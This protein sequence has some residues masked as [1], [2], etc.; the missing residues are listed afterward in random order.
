MPGFAEVTP[1]VCGLLKHL[2]A[3]MCCHSLIINN[4]GNCKN[5]STHET[6]ING[7]VEFVTLLTHS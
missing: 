1:S 4:G 7:A 5:L 2:I 6:D 3:I